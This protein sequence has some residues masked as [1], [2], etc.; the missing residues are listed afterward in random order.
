MKAAEESLWQASSGGVDP[1]KAEEVKVREVDVSISPEFAKLLRDALA[2]VV[3]ETRPLGNDE[4]PGRIVIEGPLTEVMIIRDGKVATGQMGNF[5]SSTPKLSLLDKL[6]AN[7]KALCE[8]PPLERE[9]RLTDVTSTAD[10]LLKETAS[11]H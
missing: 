10:A 9:H 3:D 11:G 4:K 1:T 2:A 6:I 8:S 7:L 5:P